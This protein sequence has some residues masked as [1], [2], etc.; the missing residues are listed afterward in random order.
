MS[1]KRYEGEPRTAD[2]SGS[3]L[4]DENSFMKYIQI[5]A[6]SPEAAGARARYIKNLN[7]LISEGAEAGPFV[8]DQTKNNS[9]D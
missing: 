2:N 8:T 6:M 7:R 5:D 4:R 3:E 1:D 9:K